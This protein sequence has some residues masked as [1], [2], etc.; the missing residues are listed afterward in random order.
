MPLVSLRP[1]VISPPSIHSLWQI[2]TQATVNR[3]KT[4][5]PEMSKADLIH[6]ALTAAYGNVYRGQDSGGCTTQ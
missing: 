2:L 4:N 6:K 3:S 5:C 1:L